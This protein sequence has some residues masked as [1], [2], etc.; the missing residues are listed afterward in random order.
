M[1]RRVDELGVADRVKLG[2]MECYIHQIT[3]EERGEVIL[4]LIPVGVQYLPYPH[5]FITLPMP[6]S[7]KLPVKE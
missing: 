2:T 3:Q 4:K 5:D 1:M 7:E 6:P